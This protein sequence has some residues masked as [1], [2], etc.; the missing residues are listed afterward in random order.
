M[1][2]LLRGQRVTDALIDRGRVSSGERQYQP[3]IICA[4]GMHGTIEE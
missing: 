4:S 3:N 2:K 1:K